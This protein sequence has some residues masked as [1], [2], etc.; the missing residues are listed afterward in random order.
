MGGWGGE[1]ERWSGSVWSSC[2]GRYA[3]VPWEDMAVLRG[4]TPFAA[5]QR[6]D[7]SQAGQSLFA[8]AIP[9]FDLTSANIV[10]SNL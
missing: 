3:G 10:E 8:A 5:H 6:W 4:R 2:F 9:M 1:A 7:G